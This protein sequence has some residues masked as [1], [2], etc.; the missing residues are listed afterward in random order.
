MRQTSLWFEPEACLFHQKTLEQM[1][2]ALRKQ[3]ERCRM[4]GP[5]VLGFCSARAGETSAKQY[6]QR[7]GIEA[8]FSTS[9]CTPSTCAVRATLAP[10]RP[11]YN[12]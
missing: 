11:I 4:I 10:I 7:E 8:T 12:M 3:F 1:D 5:T 9:V 6:A 2:V